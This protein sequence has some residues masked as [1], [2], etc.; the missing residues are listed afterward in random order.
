MRFPKNMNG[1]AAPRV[2]GVIPARLAATRLP[3]KPL[4]E[5]AGRP[6]IQHVWEHARLA[7]GLTEAVVATPDT[8]IARVVESF[9]GRAVM[10][11]PEHRSGTDRVAEAAVHLNLEDADIVV[12]IQ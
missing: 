8:E 6:M 10:T 1:N 4:V 11:S 5:I 9:G 7:P 3:N 2:V 12:N